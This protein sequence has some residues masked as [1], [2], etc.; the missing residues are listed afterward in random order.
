ML[1]A[2]AK[3]KA[4]DTATLTPGDYSVSVKA[5]DSAGNAVVSDNVL[6]SLA[7]ALPPVISPTEPA[8]DNVAPLLGIG[9]PDGSR[10]RR[11]SQRDYDTQRERVG[12]GPDDVM[13]IHFDSVPATADF[14]IA[15]V[16]VLD[17]N[18]NPIPLQ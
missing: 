15:L 8:G 9:F 11:Q 7:A 18:F 5:I 3:L 13:T 17:S 14:S 1:K 16:A 2:A 12:F 10:Q 4:W 6:V